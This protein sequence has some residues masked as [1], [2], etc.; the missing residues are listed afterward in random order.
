MRNHYDLVVIGSSSAGITAAEKARKSRPEATIAC[1]SEEM[2][3]PYYRPMLT[4]LMGNP[5]VLEKTAFTLRKPQW[6]TEQNIELFLGTEVTGLDPAAR[7]LTTKEGQSC[8]WGSCV[9]ATGSVPFVPLPEALALPNVFSCRSL[10]DAQKILEASST[11]GR[12]VVI[13]GGLLG[14]E[15]AHFLNTGGKKI[16]VVELM[17]RILPRQLDETVSTWFA[18]RIGSAGVDLRLGT[19][20]KEVRG[21]DGHL[22]VSTPV[23]DLEADLVL[24]SIGVRPRTELAR[25]AGLTVNRGV[26]VDPY[27]Q[28]SDP[29]VFACGD[30]AEVGGM[31]WPL[32]MPAMR[33]GQVAGHNAVSGPETTY[34]LTIPPAALSAFSTRIFSVGQLEKGEVLEKKADDDNGLRLYFEEGVL[35]G[36]LLWGDTAKGM[37][38]SKAL[39][40]KADRVTV[41]KLL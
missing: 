7:S 11:A 33:M 29:H 14:L 9:L 8:T 41:E 40:A 23:E 15:A 31:T 20:V 25:Q 1:F 27:M 38:L 2:Q 13:G 3:P 22:V 12:I 30:V 16:T 24:F 32:W 26:V 36:V 6:F 35:T 17:P 21:Q 34:V 28:T 37:A 4:E 18:D 5:A 19:Q 10:L 39:E